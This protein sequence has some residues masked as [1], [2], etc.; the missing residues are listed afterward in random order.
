M[1]SS[2]TFSVGGITVTRIDQQ[3]QLPLVAG[4][5]VLRKANNPGCGSAIPGDYPA[6]N[7]NLNTVAETLR[8]PTA[9]LAAGVYK[10]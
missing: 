2:S 9:T 1:A 3:E 8:Y 10:S 4:T 7:V 6:A 5:T